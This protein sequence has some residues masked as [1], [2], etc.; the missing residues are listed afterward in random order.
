MCTHTHTLPTVSKVLG[1]D[2]KGELNLQMF[3]GKDSYHRAEAITGQR[4]SQNRGYHRV[5]AL[6]DHSNSLL[7]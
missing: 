5:E 1:E 4:L 6:C 2:G 7:Q 3:T